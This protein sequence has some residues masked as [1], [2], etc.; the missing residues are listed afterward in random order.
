M[1]EPESCPACGAPTRP[2]RDV[3]ERAIEVTL[4]LAGSVEIAHG[5]AVEQ[6]RQAGGGL[7]ALLRFQ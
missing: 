7:G 1:G 6:L 2:L 3:V 5:Q 4:Q